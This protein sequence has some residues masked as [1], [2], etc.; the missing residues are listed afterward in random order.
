MVV[1]EHDPEIIAQSD[2]LIDLGPLSGEKGGQIMYEGPTR[3]VRAEGS[4]TG[5][6]LLGT[7]RM[8]VPK[9]RKKTQK[10][11]W[12]RVCGA[13]EHNLK[14]LTVRIPLG[15]MVCLTGVSGSGKST[16]AE[17][18]LYKGIKRLKNNSQGRPGQ[19]RSIE[20]AASVSDVHLV[21]Q[22]ALGRTPRANLLTYTKAM[23]AVRKLFAETETARTMG[24]GPSYFSF[25]VKGGRCET[26]RGDG[27]ERVEM[28]FLSDVYI[29]CA[30][31][32]GKRFNQKVL[33]VRYQ[34][35]TIHEVLN[36][37]VE[38]AL[39]FFKDNTAIVRALTPV[40]SV[41]LGYIRLGQPLNTFSGGEA[42]RL[43]LSVH[44]KET[45]E[46]GHLFVF[47]EPTTG[48][49]M[50]EIGIL[51]SALRHLTEK[52][53]SVLMIEHNM[54]VIK[55]ADWV[56]DLGPE[57]GDDGGRLV[58][59]GT[60][61]QV[62][63]HAT[64]HTG[65]Y[66]KSYLALEWNFF[67]DASSDAPSFESVLEPMG[68]YSAGIS[69]SGAREHNLNNLTLSIP[70]NELVVITGVSGSGK[71]S[72]A[73]DT[74]FAEGQRRYLESLTPYVRQFIQVLEKPDVDM[75]SGLPPTVAIEQRISHASR[76]STVGTLTEI[77]HFFR[78]LFSKLGTPHC[79][80]CGRPLE[81]LSQESLITRVLH[82]Y[83]NRKALLLAPL[84]YG[85]K[86]FHR[87]LLSK[88]Y[89]KGYQR[90]R[91]DGSI[92]ELEKNMALSR[93]HS[94]TIELLMKSERVEEKT[95]RE[96]LE[97]GRGT[98]IVVDH[99]GQDHCFSLHGNCP[100]CG[101]GVEPPDPLLFSFNSPRGACPEC[102]GIGR[103]MTKKQVN[104]SCG[105]CGGS[106]LRKEALS[107]RVQGHTIWELVQKSARELLDELKTWSFG[108]RE[109]S[110]ISPILSEVKTRLSFLCRLGLD[111]L[112]LDRS[113]D[114]L[115]G[116]EAQRVRLAAQLGSNLTGVL[117]VLDEPTIGL[118]PRDNQMLLSALKALR[119]QGNT[120][121]VVEHDD[122]TIRQADT[123]IDLGPGGGKD[124]GKIVTMGRPA[125]LQ[126]TK[127]S[128][129]FDWMSAVVQP[130][131][132]KPRSVKRSPKIR[133]QDASAHNLKHVS[134][135]FP[136]RT[137]M[138]VT[139]VSGS[140]KS[141]L[142]KHTLFNGIQN[143]I[144]KQKQSCRRM[145]GY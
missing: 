101:I 39:V 53:H 105:T 25:N 8:Q 110:I 123:V 137:L 77:Y 141:T 42:Q 63:C 38:E 35:K 100:V 145:P 10:N 62:A 142:V 44:L 74:I 18:I 16:L 72:L 112:S 57:G 90:A 27:F 66:L 64:S 60:P 12:L 5:Q 97:I 121:L 96:A 134:V 144:L 98:V 51:L 135:D 75:I 126:R 52:G 82:T 21:N 114:T 125:D 93:Y 88:L 103:K 23:N 33:T 26:C 17:E 22:Q 79:S 67:N 24:L 132:Q 116:G 15:L 91:I 139:G 117:Y 29:T 65:R 113:G 54:E 81:T 31:C 106:R 119:D 7:R 127:G 89:A 49:H 3:K 2:Y 78:L 9:T 129:T 41:G 50:E 92:I 87:G 76:R 95:L 47:D 43:K 61:E 94:H 99:H 36:L 124:G 130:A 102:D 115:S 80:G 14:N 136:L 84:I 108:D 118:H 37:T 4:K 32:G 48:L 71:S 28:Q 107:I 69:I 46:A 58:T 83:Q 73:F 1:V 70:R 104:R 143:R 140:G 19:Y 34:N 131:N 45:A 85:K 68:E 56:I 86:G 59:Q 120:V 109:K 128:K 133:L 138:A 20:G 122:E 11:A 13:T 40:A 55:T 111:Y 6:Y 30:E